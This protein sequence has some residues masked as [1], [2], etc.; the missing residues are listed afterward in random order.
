MRG[1]TESEIK[2]STRSGI[3]NHILCKIILRTSTDNKCRMFQQLD[4]KMYHIISAFPIL[5]KEE[6]IKRHGRVYAYARKRVKLDK[7]LVPEFAE[8]SHE[9]KVTILWNQQVKPDNCSL[10]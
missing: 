2:R 8:T 4:E 7:E 10:Q 6:Y 3:K 1:E 9:S 5:A